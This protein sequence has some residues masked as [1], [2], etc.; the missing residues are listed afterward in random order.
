VIA[1]PLDDDDPR[2]ERHSGGDGHNG[3]EW[4]DGDQARAAA[5]YA[6]LSGNAKV[7]FDL[8][9]DHPGECLDADWLAGHLGGRT[10]GESA[11]RGRHS[12]S[13]SLSALNRPHA[14]S[15]RRYPFYWWKGTGGKPTQYAMKPHVAALFHAAR[16]ARA[17][18]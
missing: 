11:E 6:S 15:G 18:R 9:V 7:I 5:F 1:V 16:Q 8:M 17:D 13:G 14:E 10:P 4:G 12:V 2:W 3:P